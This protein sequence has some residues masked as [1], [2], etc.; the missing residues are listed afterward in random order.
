MELRRGESF[1]RWLGKKEQ[2]GENGT[3]KTTL[4][5]REVDWVWGSLLGCPID[6]GMYVERRV[7]PLF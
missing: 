3:R 4:G 7:G 2:D 1:R 6:E 5:R